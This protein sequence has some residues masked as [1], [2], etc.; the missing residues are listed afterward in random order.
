MRSTGGQSP[1]SS[2]ILLFFFSTATAFLPL[3][4]IFN[5]TRTKDKGLWTVSA[6]GPPGGAFAPAPGP[7]PQQGFQGAPPM[8]QQGFQGGQPMHQPGF[9][10][11]FAQAP[12]QG[13]APQQPGVYYPPQQQQQFAPGTAPMHQPVPQQGYAPYPAGQS[14]SPVGVAGPPQAQPHVTT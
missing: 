11:G 10:P 6:T 5:L 4:L 13:W 14:P 8:Q 12:Q 2:V 1:K 9:Q 7:Q 3:A